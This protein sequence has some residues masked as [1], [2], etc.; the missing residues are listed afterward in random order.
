MRRDNDRAVKPGIHRAA[1]LGMLVL[2]SA[3]FGHARADTPP[4]ASTAPADKAVSGK[5]PIPLNDLMKSRDGFKTLPPWPKDMVK[6]GDKHHAMREVFVGE[7][8]V[9][10]YEASDGLVALKDQPYDEFVHVVHGE[11][12]LT[13]DGGK[14]MHFKAG[15][16]FIVPKGFSGSWE[17]RAGFRELIVV[18]TKAYERAVA[19]LFP[20]DAH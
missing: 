11:C 18:E 16:L 3:G 6:W 12:I 17:G 15:D 4:P 5:A 14:P 9:D 8:A 1:L 19:A 13:P 20:P 2:S 10:V 7:F